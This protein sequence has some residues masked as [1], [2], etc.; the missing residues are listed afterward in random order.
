MSD[1]I[2][3]YVS[4]AL[5]ILIGSPLDI[6]KSRLQ[7]SSSRGA[8]Y[9]FPSVSSYL[10]GTTPPLLTYGALNSILFATYNR[11][12][13]LLPD[14]LTGIWIAGAAGGLTS[15]ILSAPTEVVKTRAQVTGAG[16][17]EVTRGL[18][19]RYGPHGLYL[20]GTITAARDAIG[21][22]WYF[23]AYEGVRRYW[24]EEQRDQAGV[25][26]FAGGVA[27]VA[28]WASIYPLDVVKTRVQTQL[29][30]ETWGETRG[31]L[32]GAGKRTS[33]HG[34]LGAGECAKMLYREAG[35][36][37]FFDGMGVCMARAFLVNA[38]QWAIYEY[39][40]RALKAPAC[41]GAREEFTEVA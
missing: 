29:F 23:A 20:G 1:F 34:G 32:G 3:G 16:S 11:T 15:F 6:I 7:A 19:R 37:G 13:P 5:S 28:T 30:P 22:G 26:L 25:I 24:E 41:L 27:G 10:R 12:L 21:Y 36:R 9:N 4:G 39:I 40:M 31:L 18:W 35:Y 8:T 33:W 17:W 14:T 38:V 2:A